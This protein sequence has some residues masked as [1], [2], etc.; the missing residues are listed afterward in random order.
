MMFIIFGALYLISRGLMFLGIVDIG[1]VLMGL[2][3]TLAGVGLVVEGF[4][5]RTK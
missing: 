3:A 5:P 4:Y 1:D 2:F